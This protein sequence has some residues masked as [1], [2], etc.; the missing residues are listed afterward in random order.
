MLLIYF[1]ILMKKIAIV[2]SVF[3]S[4]FMMAQVNWMSMDQALE[5]QKKTPK[6]IMI[7]F[8]TDWCSMCKM[9]DKNT[10]SN[11]VI[12]EYI[13]DNYYAVK[14]NSEGNEN[15]TFQ[16][17]KFNNPDFNPKRKPTYGGG[18]Q[19]QFVTYFGVK[20]YPTTVFLDEDQKPL[21]GLVGYFNPRDMEAYLALFATNEFKK[22]KT[23]QEW[24]SYR[25]KFKHKIKS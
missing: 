10:F 15:V 3:S 12:T 11:P 5:A 20:G 25:E 18:P 9:M 4:M 13:N 16:G 21:T 14:F 17:K 6:K 19:H 22:I 23:Q 2:F 24:Q 7:K 8:Y 1:S